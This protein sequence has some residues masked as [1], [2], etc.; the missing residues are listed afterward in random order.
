MK[1][2]YYLT[3][4]FFCLFLSNY[5]VIGQSNQVEKNYYKWF[6]QAVGLE[7]TSIFNGTRYVK[8][9][10]TEEGIHKFFKGDTFVLGTV[11]FDGETFYDIP[12]KY[13]IHEDELIASLSST[14]GESILQLNKV[15]ITAFSIYNQKF[16]FIDTVN[17][18]VHLNG[19]YEVAFID[20]KITLYI[21]YHK[22][23]KEYIKRKTLFH[24]FLPQQNYYFF[25]NEQYYQINKKTDVIKVFPSLKK[26]INHFFKTNQKLYKTNKNNFMKDLTK[27]I[28]NSLI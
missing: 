18:K 5:S 15:F 22:A 19:F 7:N 23:I 12:L 26:E 6:D 24:K 2:N 8:K 21:Q 3:S 9:Y 14:Y 16:K 25:Y 4:L 28:S 13:D 20:K 17:N 11:N 1:I 10:R 27:D